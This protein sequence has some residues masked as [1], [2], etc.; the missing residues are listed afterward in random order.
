MRKV[1]RCWITVTGCKAGRDA[2][3][4]S[5]IRPVEAFSNGPMGNSSAD[6]AGIAP[7]RAKKGRPRCFTDGGKILCF[8]LRLYHVFFVTTTDS[9]E[10][11]G[12]L[13]I[14]RVWYVMAVLSHLWDNLSAGGE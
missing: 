12:G 4:P 6:P 7:E 9:G 5:N 11:N 14:N 13:C 10:K 2:D 1:V 8:L 3:T